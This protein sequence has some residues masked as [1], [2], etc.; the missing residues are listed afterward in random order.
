MVYW[1]LRDQNPMNHWKY[2]PAMVAASVLIVAQ[3]ILAFFIF[4]LSG[5]RVLQWIGWI[6]W[7]VSMYFGIAPIYIFRKKGGVPAGESYMK[8]TRLVDSGPYAIIRHPQYMAG[9]LLGISMMLLSQHWLVIALGVI[10]V[11]L[12]YHDIQKADREGIEKFGDEYL[13]YMEKVPRSNFILGIV[14]WLRRSS[15]ESEHK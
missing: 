7:L 5:V 15:S 11:V 10:S 1:V 3:Y 4:K 6:T 12:F 9:V 2:T 8:T 13:A 14:R